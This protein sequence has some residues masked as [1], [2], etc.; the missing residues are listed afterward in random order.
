LRKKR[1]GDGIG[2]SVR[3]KKGGLHPGQVSQ[4]VFIFRSGG[5]EEPRVVKHMNATWKHRGGW[6]EKKRGVSP[7]R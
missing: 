2:K 1:G 5:G 6:T 3:L 4:G 7:C